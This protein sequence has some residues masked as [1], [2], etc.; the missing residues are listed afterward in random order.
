M[1]HNILKRAAAAAAAALVLSSAAY[2]AD[3]STRAAA[4]AAA[5]LFNILCFI[6]YVNSYNLILAIQTRLNR[7]S[8]S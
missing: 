4:A 7:R 8:D 2:A 3:D 1:K 6:I 5:A